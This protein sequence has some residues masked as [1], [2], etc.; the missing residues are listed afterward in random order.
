MSADAFQKLIGLLEHRHSSPLKEEVTF[1][2]EY[3]MV[4][5]N[6]IDADGWEQSATATNCCHAMIDVG[7]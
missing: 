7:E 6:I 1:N 3:I 5:K 4:F 2:F